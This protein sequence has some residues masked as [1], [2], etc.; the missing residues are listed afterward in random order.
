MCLSHAGIRVV[1]GC[2]LGGLCPMKIGY[3]P[4]NKQEDELVGSYL[5]GW[6][7]YGIRDSLSK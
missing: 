3:F 7:G 2:R 5:R 4:G 6:Q 1:S